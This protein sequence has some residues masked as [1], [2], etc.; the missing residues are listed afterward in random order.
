MPG[1]ELVHKMHRN[2]ETPKMPSHDCSVVVAVAG[3]EMG[4]EA[5]EESVAPVDQIAPSN[6]YLPKYQNH[7]GEVHIQNSL[8]IREM[9]AADTGFAGRK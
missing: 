4:L 6:Q 1:L 5:V 9:M 8:N 3:V 2:P 7:L